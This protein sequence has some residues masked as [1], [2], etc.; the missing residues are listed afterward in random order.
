ME[1]MSDKIIKKTVDAIRKKVEKYLKPMSSKIF[2]VI[3]YK[4][5]DKIYEEDIKILLND[6]VKKYHNTLP[7]YTNGDFFSLYLSNQSDSIGLVPLA[8]L[9]HEKEMNFN[10]THSYCD[11]DFYDNKYIDHVILKVDA[12]Q[13]NL[14]DE[15]SITINYEKAIE[16]IFKLH[17]R[18]LVFSKLINETIDSQNKNDNKSTQISIV[19]LMLE[20]NPRYSKNDILK[21]LGERNFFGVSLL[22]QILLFLSLKIEKKDNEIDVNMTNIQVIIDETAPSAEY[23]FLHE[24]LEMSSEPSKIRLEHG[25][26]NSIIS[27]KVYFSDGIKL[28]KTDLEKDDYFLNI[29]NLLN[30]NDED[31]KKEIE[32]NYQHTVKNPN[33]DKEDKEIKNEY[34]RTEGNYI[35]IKV[36][37][38]MVLSLPLDENEKPNSDIYIP[39]CL[40]DKDNIKTVDILTVG[41]AEHNRALA[42]LINKHRFEYKDNRLFGFMDN[43]FDMIYK[44][45]NLDN[46]EKHG[47]SYN[48]FMGLNQ[49]VSGWNYIF[50]VRRDDEDGNSQNSDV[51]LLTFKL[52]DV[53]NSKKKQNFNIVSIYG[54]SAVASVLGINMFI[55]EL[56]LRKIYT[57]ALFEGEF[58]RM[59]DDFKITNPRGTATTFFF[60][61]KDETSGK[62]KIKVEIMNNFSKKCYQYQFNVDKEK[63]QNIL[64]I[65][66]KKIISHR[67]FG[68]VT[69]RYE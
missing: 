63:Y 62:T 18:E 2:D 45:V 51:K 54:F 25:G 8:K 65:D 41:G 36:P 61:E 12:R 16:S 52:K 30:K 14:N 11:W 24:L 57:N 66:K 6:L 43:H 59:F 13:L 35:Y 50:D 58:S 49:P 68:R 38:K 32:S 64:W 33:L 22:S 47:N 37:I 7:T 21:M 20:D 34:I 9:S 55:A 69:T 31:N 26:Q 17:A 42:H 53:T 56:S 4:D 40:N 3:G 67:Q 27:A 48:F 23:H 44:V 28:A 46:S 39:A 5:K 19:D 60:K 1:K 10:I 29:C 15:N